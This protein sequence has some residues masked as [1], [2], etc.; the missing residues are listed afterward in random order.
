M[1]TMKD[2]PPIIEY[3]LAKPSLRHRYRIWDGVHLVLVLAS[4]L[5]AGYAQ[6]IMPGGY[7]WDYRWE[8]ANFLMNIAAFSSAI[9]FIAGLR[10]IFVMGRRRVPVLFLAGTLMAGALPILMSFFSKRW[11][12]NNFA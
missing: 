1:E 6:S 3:A 10:A 2:G 9:L 5:L 11:G 12:Q 8:F 7:G 4:Y